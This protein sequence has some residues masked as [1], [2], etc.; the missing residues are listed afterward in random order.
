MVT[1]IRMP[2]TGT[3][4]GIQAAA[5]LREHRPSV[6][7]GGA[8]PVH[9][10]RLRDRAARARLGR[11]RLPAQGAGRPASTSWPRAI[12]AVASRR[13]GDRPA[14]GRRAGAGRARTTA[15]RPGLADPAGAGDPGRDGAG[16]EQRGHRG[17]AVRL[18]AGGRE[19]HQLDLRQ[20]GADRGEGRQPPGQGGAAV[21]HRGAGAGREADLP[22][23]G[24]AS[25]IGRVLR[26]CED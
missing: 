9:R 25:T 19:A 15:A 3:D 5:W 20:A 11:P 8:E 24:G 7:R 21:P 14:G 22:A 6:G 1:D 12:R 26:P 2:P 13:L 4:E 23:A 18:R 10:A 16:Q 17:R